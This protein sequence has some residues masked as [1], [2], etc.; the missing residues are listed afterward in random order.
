MLHKIFPIVL[1]AALLQGC[2]APDSAK[3]VG[4]AKQ[5]LDELKLTIDA[6]RRGVQETTVA[7]LE[8]LHSLEYKVLEIDGKLA[9]VDLETAFADLGKERWDCFHIEERAES[10]RVFCKR[11]PKT[12]LKYIPRMF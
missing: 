7:E 2:E 1:S 3:L 12:Y 9:T 6:S 11:N 8:K 10:L 4:D 5:V